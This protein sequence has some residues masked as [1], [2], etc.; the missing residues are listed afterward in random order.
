M[1]KKVRFPNTAKV[2]VHNANPISYL[3]VKMDFQLKAAQ[4]LRAY[5][6]V[7]SLHLCWHYVRKGLRKRNIKVDFH[8]RVL[9]LRAYERDPS[10]A[11]HV[12]KHV[13]TAC[14]KR[15]IR[16]QLLR[17]QQFIIFTINSES[18]TN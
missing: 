10:V 3:N 15:L 5:G 6:H 7:D 18:K 16:I 17:L 1:L 11:L 9:I 4:I 12:E 13:Q 8:R 14:L 2:Q